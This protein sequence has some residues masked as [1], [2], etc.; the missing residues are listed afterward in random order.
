MA[1]NMEAPVKITDAEGQRLTLLTTDS[2]LVG[3]A[4][5]RRGKRVGFPGLLPGTEIPTGEVFADSS[6]ATAVP[7]V[8]I[9]VGDEGGSGGVTVRDGT[10]QPAINLNG[11]S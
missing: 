6:T 11:A 9:A 5:S 2:L 1:E 10:G 4:V 3:R 8:W 7:D